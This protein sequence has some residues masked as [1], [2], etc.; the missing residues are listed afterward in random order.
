[1]NKPKILFLDLET[2]PNIGYIWGKWEQNVIDF[3]KEWEILSFAYKWAD[4]KTVHC[5]T[6]SHFNDPTDKSLV[7]ALWKIMN[8]C[9]VMVAHNGDQFDNKK[10]KARFLVHGLTPPSP[11]KTVD[12]KKIAKGQFNFNSNAL[13]DLGKALGVGRKE[14]TGGFDLWLGCMANKRASWRLMTKYN[15]QDVLL[16][17]RVY[18]KLLPWANNHPNVSSWIGDR[19]CPKCAGTR[20]KSKGLVYTRTSAFRKYVCLGC[21]GYSRLRIAEKNLKPKIV[22]L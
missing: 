8:E 4:K 3:K 16:L 7:K 20:L 9:D 6:R 18:L 21:G 22:N 11:Y 5:V 1:M 10:A 13:D 15:K 14:K 2:S 19:A 17:E 12:T